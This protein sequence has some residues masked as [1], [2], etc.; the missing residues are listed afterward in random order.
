MSLADFDEIAE[1]FYASRPGRMLC[2]IVHFLRK[3]SPV[4]VPKNLSDG[5]SSRYTLGLTSRTF[6]SFGCIQE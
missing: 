3:R 4:Q 1:R 2:D 6:S 5:P